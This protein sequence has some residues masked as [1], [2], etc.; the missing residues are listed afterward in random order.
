MTELSYAY[1][2]PSAWTPGD[3]SL[4]TSG[5]TTTGGAAA[6]PFFFSGSPGS[7]HEVDGHEQGEHSAGSALAVLRDDQPY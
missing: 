6:H 3:L 5:G 1:L 7:H 4:A 2:T